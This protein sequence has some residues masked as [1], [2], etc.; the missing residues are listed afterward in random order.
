MHSHIVSALTSAIYRQD[1]WGQSKNY[2]GVES[3][4]LKGRFWPKAVLQIELIG[5]MLRRAAF[6]PKQPF[7]LYSRKHDLYLRLTSLVAVS[8][9]SN[10]CNKR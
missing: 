1:K 10:S 7:S 2:P 3:D 5:Y 8:R 9:H 6:D 4:Y